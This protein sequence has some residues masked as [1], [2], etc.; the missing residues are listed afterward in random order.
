MDG[1][2]VKELAERTATPGQ[3]TSPDL[4]VLPAGWTIHDPAK[5]VAPGPAADALKVYSL[6]AVRDYLAANRDTL[7]LSKLVVHVVSPQVV[8]LL[9]PLQERARNREVFVEATAQNLTDGFLGK[10]MASDEFII[11]LQTRFEGSEART[12]V[13]KLFSNISHEAVRTSQDDGITQ[14]VTAKSG[15]AL[16]TEAP[17][18]NPIDLVPFRTF[19]EVAQP[20]SLFALRVNQS[21]QVGMFE[22][23]GGAWR[24]EAVNSIAAWLHRALALVEA[25]V[26]VLA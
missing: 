26:S 14:T 10:W 3:L 17:I 18:P 12:G 9:G 2:F 21:M 7:D 19:R 5:F 25:N 16:K 8:R 11:G 24:L 20:V 1:T 13:L 4:A 23:D 15:I 6:G 22:A